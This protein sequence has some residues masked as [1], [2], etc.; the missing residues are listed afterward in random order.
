MRGYILCIAGVVLLSAVLSVIAPSG[1]MGKFIKGMTKL[2]VVAVLVAPFLSF[3]RGEGFTFE[4]KQLFEDDSYLR[5]C[6][7]LLEE[8]DER[9]VKRLLQEK[10]GIEA[11]V[12]AERAED[13]S[14]KKISVKV[15][16]SG[17]Y[18]QDKHIDMIADVEKLLC[19]TYGCEA[20]VV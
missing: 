11:E 9:A 1:K 13:L 19:E 4:S 15:T 12:N 14:L 8:D 7:E 18:G 2:A 20:E 3:A 17:I 5:S 16:D 10:F 6:M